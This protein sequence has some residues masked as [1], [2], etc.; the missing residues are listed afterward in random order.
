MSANVTE[1]NAARFIPRVRVDF[2][3]LEDG[4]KVWTSIK[5]EPMLR[6]VLSP[7]MTVR[8]HDHDGNTCDAVVE[9]LRGAIVYFRMDVTTWTDGP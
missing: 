8:L 4:D 7:G 2:N 3:E 5:R 1:G 9:A 6:G